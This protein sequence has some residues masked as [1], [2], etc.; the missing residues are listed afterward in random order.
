MRRSARCIEASESVAS[1]SGSEYVQYGEVD[2]AAGFVYQDVEVDLMWFKEHFYGYG[3]RTDIGEL[4]F[5]QSMK[6]T[7]HW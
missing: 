4:K 2:M 3:T 7:W 6:H 1:I 5:L